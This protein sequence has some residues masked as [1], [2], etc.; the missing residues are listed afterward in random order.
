MTRTRVLLR[1]C[2]A[3]YLARGTRGAATLAAAS[4]SGRVASGYEHSCAIT[5]AG[6]LLCWGSNDHGQLNVPPGFTWAKVSTGKYHS[7]GITTSATLLCW[8]RDKHHE[9]ETLAG[10]SWSDVSA[11]SSY[12]CAL[13]TTGKAVCWGNNRLGEADVPKGV[14]TQLNS[15][16]GEHVCGLETSRAI[17]C[18]GGGWDGQLNVPGGF[19]WSSVSTGWLHSCGVVEARRPGA[20]PAATGGGGPVPT[21]RGPPVEGDAIGA[22][23]CWGN[24]D[25]AQ[26]D[27]P[28]LSPHD[29]SR[30]V[31]VSAGHS[32]TCGVTDVGAVKCWGHLALGLSKLPLGVKWESVSAGYYHACGYGREGTLHCWGLDYDGQTEVPEGFDFASGCAAAASPSEHKQGRGGCPAEQLAHAGGGY[33]DRAAVIAECLRVGCGFYVWANYEGDVGEFAG[34]AWFCHEDYYD[35]TRNGQDWVGWEVGRPKSFGCSASDGDVRLS[36]YPRGEI[37]F[38]QSGAWSTLCGELDLPTSTVICRQ[39]GYARAA[40]TY[41]YWGQEFA[42]D[43]FAAPRCTG[44]EGTL[45]ECAAP[46]LKCVTGHGTDQ[47]AF[48]VIY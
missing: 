36:Q 27:P 48:K 29:G 38:Y 11:G 30:W 8:G 42:A 23:L 24:N 40:L 12:T 20:Q 43:G 32:F 17:A 22:I 16:F 9:A 47:G 28:A 18:W 5:A 2:L 7:C 19:E 6:A 10:F 3:L 14:F 4:C 15:G 37:F 41:N 34:R 35:E 39:L 33:A 26:L 44:H 25:F 45:S 13:T 31:S 46:I 1:L 21:G